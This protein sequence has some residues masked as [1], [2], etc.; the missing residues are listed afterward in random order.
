MRALVLYDSLYG[1][2]EKVAQSI[3]S[4]MAGTLEVRTAKVGAVSPADLA[5]LD[6]LVVGCPTQMWRPTRGITGFLDSVEGKS[7]KGVRAA[8]F[9]TRLP[10]RLAGSAARR[11]DKKLKQLGCQV[12]SPPAQFVVQ[13]TE[14]PLREGELSRA[15]DWG[16]ELAAEVARRD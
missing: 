8:A 3:A 14:G 9:D 16:R 7:L 15:E 10:S 6:V 1:N 2:T 13:G 11:L 12:V 5:G 4:G